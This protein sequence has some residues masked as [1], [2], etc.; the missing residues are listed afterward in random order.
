MIWRICGTFGLAAA[1]VPVCYAA[2]DPLPLYRDP[3][4]QLD[5]RVD[6][7]VQRLSSDE[8]IALLSTSAPAMPRLG[9]PALQRLQ[10][11]P[12]RRRLDAA[13]DDVPGPDRDG[14]DVGPAARP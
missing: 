13:D 11:E 14:C 1:L 12:A 7:L 4:Q 6:D 9:I 8:K 5:R 3:A 2:A 10:S